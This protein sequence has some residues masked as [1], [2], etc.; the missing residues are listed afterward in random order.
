MQPVSLTQLLRETQK[1]VQHQ[2]RVSRKC[3]AAFQELTAI[4]HEQNANDAM[5]PPK[6]V[7]GVVD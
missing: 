2:F 5:R 3:V 7:A 6:D 4:Y 1:L